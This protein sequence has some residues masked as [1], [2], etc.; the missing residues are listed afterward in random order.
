MIATKS[1]DVF[2][3]SHGR[4]GTKFLANYFNTNF[5]GVT[6]FHEPPPSY[7]LRV[8]SNLYFTGLL[9]R[10]Q[11]ATIYCRRRARI[12]N[13]IPPSALYIES[14]PFA[15]G[16]ADAFTTFQP[17]PVIIHIVRDPREFVRSAFNHGSAHG[18]KW[19]A[20]QLIPFWEPPLRRYRA[21]ASQ[22]SRIGHFAAHWLHVNQ[23]LGHIGQDYARYYR[24]KFE[25][26]FDAESPRFSELCEVIGLE[27]PGADVPLTRSQPINRGKFHQISSWPEWTAEQCRELHD[28]CSP[29]M[30]EYGYGTEPEWL[31]C[32]G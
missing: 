31:E 9:S 6:A 13:D 26:L 18:R 17:P 22:R 4:T 24:F 8:C 19:L 12:L 30:E 15:Y 2:I 16:F 20:T 3:L 10:A 1:P 11:M 28:I 27:Y 7:W 21:A 23:Y 25:E 29:L 5:E 14:N 32:I